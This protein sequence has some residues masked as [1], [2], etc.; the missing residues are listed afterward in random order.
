M[1]FLASSNKNKIDRNIRDGILTKIFRPDS[2]FNNIYK[3]IFF[4]VQLSI[5]MCCWLMK[6]PIFKLAQGISGFAV[7]VIDDCCQK[8]MHFSHELLSQHVMVE[9]LINAS[10]NKPFSQLLSSIVTNAFEWEY[11]ITPTKWFSLHHKCESF[12]I[13]WRPIYFFGI[14]MWVWSLQPKFK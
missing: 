6:N 5:E 10:N 11:L 3:D 1:A 14:I 2:S 7:I 9:I 13:E 4:P 12:T 8:I